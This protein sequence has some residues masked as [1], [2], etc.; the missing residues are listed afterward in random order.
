M[1]LKSGRLVPAC[2]PS[3]HCGRS[4]HSELLAH[5]QEVIRDRWL[6]CNLQRESVEDTGNLKW[7]SEERKPTE[8]QETDDSARNADG[9][10]KRLEETGVGVIWGH[11]SFKE[12]HVCARGMFYLT[13]SASKEANVRLT[14]W[15]AVWIL[16][17]QSNALVYN[18][19]I[20]ISYCLLYS[21]TEGPILS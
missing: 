12:G 8:L 3:S 18:I 6:R 7:L 14:A 21:K 16:H 13:A 17:L 5:S 2:W 10:K 1:W 4:T 9:L 15:E 20:L 19:I 11:W